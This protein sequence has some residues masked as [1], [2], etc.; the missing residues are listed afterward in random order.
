MKNFCLFLALSLLLPAI[1]HAQVVFTE[2]M[3]DLEGS[4]SGREWV[5]VTN[6][7]GA[8]DVSSWKFFENGTNHF[9]TLIQGDASIET[10][11]FFVIADNPE[12]FLIDWPEFSGTLFD[13]SF[14]LKNTGETISLKNDELVEIDS[15][16][17]SPTW[18][19]EG[20]S[21]S[22]QKVSGLWVAA[23]PTPGLINIGNV[24]PPEITETTN[25]QESIQPPATSVTQSFSPK[26]TISAFIQDR[27]SVVVIGGNIVFRG[28]ALGIA[29]EPLGG[30]RY[31]WNFG[32]GEM[33]DGKNVSHI[34]QYEGE[35]IAVLTVSTGQ[36]SASDRMIIRVVPARVIVSAVGPKGDFYISLTNESEYELNLSG[37]ILQSGNKTFLIPQNCSGAKLLKRIIAIFASVFLSSSTTENVSINFFA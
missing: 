33:Q 15:V 11:E 13:S 1:V 17:Y 28:T 25:P 6:N 22:L 32:D 14:S 2:I 18:G 24:A 26:P 34:Y 16:D 31:V 21:E 23:T 3:Y 20:D 4:D 36:Y 19:A 27:E 35:Y 30:A 5:E 9:I 8:V 10:S 29:G 7:G 37:W 12:K